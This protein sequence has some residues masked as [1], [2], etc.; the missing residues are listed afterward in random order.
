MREALTVLALGGSM[1]GGC[2]RGAQ[3]PAVPFQRLWTGVTEPSLA[4]KSLYSVARAGF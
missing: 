2:H 4:K 3:P 1:E